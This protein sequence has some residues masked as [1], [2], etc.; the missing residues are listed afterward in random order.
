MNAQTINQLKMHRAILDLRSQAIED[1]IS[2]PGEI[3]RVTHR[4]IDKYLMALQGLRDAFQKLGH[5]ITFSGWMDFKD[6][7]D[8]SILA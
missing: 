2:D 3:D 4:A 1:R 5:T 7:E 6:G 8:D